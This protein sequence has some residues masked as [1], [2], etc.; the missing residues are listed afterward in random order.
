VRGESAA[1]CADDAGLAHAIGKCHR[2]M[3]L[4]W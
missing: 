4:R 2:E 3:S 1:A